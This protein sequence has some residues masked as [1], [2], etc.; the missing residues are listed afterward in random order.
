MITVTNV[1]ALVAAVY[2]VLRLVSLAITWEESFDD[3]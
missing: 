3:A 1:V 2:L